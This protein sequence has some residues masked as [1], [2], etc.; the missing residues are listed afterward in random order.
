MMIKNPRNL[1]VTKFDPTIQNW[2]PVCHL[3]WRGRFLDIPG[4]FTGY[5]H[6]ILQPSADGNSTDF[7]HFEIF[8]GII[9]YLIK[10]VG[11]TYSDTE[12]GFKAMNEALKERAGNPKR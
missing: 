8:S 11:K 10:Y 7:E 4:L 12:E 5:H 2:S 1:K 9:A 6:F 3:H